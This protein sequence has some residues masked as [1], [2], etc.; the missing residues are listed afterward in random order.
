MTEFLYNKI[1]TTYQDSEAYKYVISDPLVAL[2]KLLYK[3]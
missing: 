1:I 2:S 3:L